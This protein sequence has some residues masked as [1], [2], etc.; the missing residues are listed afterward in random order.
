MIT[1]V[2]WAALVLLIPESLTSLI[3]SRSGIPYSGQV[4]L[5]AAAFVIAETLFRLLITTKSVVS[6]TMAISS[7]EKN[8][9]S[10]LA[11]LSPGEKAILVQFI[12]SGEATRWLN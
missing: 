11:A 7:V 5:F 2:V 8:L 6:D 4:V 9:T 3:T 12:S 1:I 10:N